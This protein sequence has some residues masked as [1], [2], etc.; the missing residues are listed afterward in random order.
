[1]T[2][3]RST[4]CDALEAVVRRDP[5]GRGLAGFRTQ[6]RW[7]AAGQL[8]QAAHELAAARSVAIVTGFC[9]TAAN[10]PAAETDGPPGALYLARALAALGIETALI[11]DRFGLPLLECGCRLWGLD[12]ELIEMPLG[13][14]KAPSHGGDA[15]D[16]SECFLNSPRGG[17]LTHLISIERVGPSH[18]PDS[19]AA[20]A[21]SGPPPLE[22]FL[23]D[24]PPEHRDVCHN[25]RGQPIDA[26]T[27]P[28][29]RLF[30]AAAARRPAIKTIGIGDGGNE[31]GMG[32]LPWETLRAALPGEDAGRIICRIAT[33]YLI[34]AGISNW[35]AYG[36][37]CALIALRGRGELLPGWD[38]ESQVRLIEHLVREAGAVDGVTR[39]PEPTVDGVRMEDYSIALGETIR[40]ARQF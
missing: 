24:V 30:A 15:G 1:M 8:E 27:A 31:I 3:L 5:G 17:R 10:P 22:E 4:T 25:M 28:A 26:Y 21:R 7:L 39:K 18:T 19:L 38:G 34:V 9:I 37:A 12:S 36:L 14:A 16:W 40:A 35:G 11:S 23:R 20:Q 29:H 13:N 6:G 2:P 33:D 32:S